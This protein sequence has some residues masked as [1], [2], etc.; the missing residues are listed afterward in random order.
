MD[1]ELL[2]IH[3]AV[4]NASLESNERYHRLVAAMRDVVFTISPDGRFTSLN[5]AFETITGWTCAE[6]LGKEFVPIVHPDD[7][8]LAVDEFHRILS[9]EE[10]RPIFELRIHTRWGGYCVAEFLETPE[11]Q[12]R[13]IVG[14]LGIAR[15]ITPRKQ[16]EQALRQ[17]HEELEMRVMDRTCELAQANAVLRQQQQQL[18]QAAKLASIGELATGVAHELNNPLNNISLMIGNELDHL[19]NGEFQEEKMVCELQLVQQQ[20]ARAACIVNQLR[21]FGRSARHEMVPLS[22]HEILSSSLGLV[23]HQL[24]LDNITVRTQWPDGP[25]QVLGDPLQLEQVFVNLFTNAHH[26][27]ATVTIKEIL[28]TTSVGSGSVQVTVR[29]TGC[30]MPSDIQERVFDP[31]FTTKAVGEGT[32]LGLSIAYG[33]IQSHKGTMFV[34]STPG[35]GS[36]FGVSLPLVDE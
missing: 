6:W 25:V 3:E 31:F 33:I 32:G 7:L 15:D 28:I 27:L 13:E 22:L 30:G 16:A 14:L 24:E 29:D 18:L 11:R 9:G 26:A 19:R 17:A 23:R 35:R 5:P 21:T 36:S 2:H 12:D 20:I 8:P 10:A 34:D 1:H 4:F